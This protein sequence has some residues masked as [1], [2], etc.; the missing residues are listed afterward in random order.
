[1]DQM[2]EGSNT[3]APQRYRTYRLREPFSAGSH[4]FGAF[5]ALIGLVYLLWSCDGTSS[6]IAVSLIYGLGLVMLLL[7]SGLFHGL[8]CSKDWLCTLERLDYAA[9]YFSIAATYTPVCL[10]VLPQPLGIWLLSGE[11]LLALVGMW[12]AMSRGPAGR[13]A[14]VVIF[15]IMGWAFV[16]ALP[17]L[18][19]LLAPL[20]FNLLILGGAFYSI[21]AV[22]FALDCQN[23]FRTRLSGHDFWHLLV[24]LGSA[25]HYG[26]VFYVLN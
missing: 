21:G 15:L 10:F 1:M 26:F 5:A 11:W 20:P 19:K 6:R 12:L 9:I 13:N 24:L 4:L 22:I 3:T 25:S 8:N 23:I 7:I 18:L 14:Q 17:S 2:G 16:I